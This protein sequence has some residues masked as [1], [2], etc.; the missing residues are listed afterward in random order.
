MQNFLLKGLI[1]GPVRWIG[2]LKALAIKPDNLN[3]IPG[4]HTEEE[5]LHMSHGI[6]AHEH[7]DTK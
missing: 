6:G 2:K 3:L 7:T 1:S 4:T 5:N